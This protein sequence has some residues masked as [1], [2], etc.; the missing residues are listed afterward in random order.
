MG[1]ILNDVF[2]ADMAEPGRPG[3]RPSVAPELAAEHYRRLENEDY[4]IKPFAEALRALK[5]N[6]S[7]RHF[8]R[9]AGVTK[10]TMHNLLQGQR[11]PDIETIESIAKSLGKRP[12]YFVE[13]R[14]GYIVAVI[15]H[16]LEWAPE[17]SVVHY[18]KI[19]NHYVGN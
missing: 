9:N 19:T 18:K 2:R 6:K 10:S 14:V 17:S 16:Y 15:S 12:S 7:V 1:R 11:T 3:K 4:T 13:Y 5:G 8:A